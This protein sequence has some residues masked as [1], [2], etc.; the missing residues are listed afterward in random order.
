M[1]LPLLRHRESRGMSVQ[2]DAGEPRLA[3]AG[4]GVV[5]QPPPEASRH[6]LVT[7]DDL[8]CDASCVLEEP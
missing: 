2:G 5:E 1:Y 8:E 4:Y 6:N 3:R 7:L